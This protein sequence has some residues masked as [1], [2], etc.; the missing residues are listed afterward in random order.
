MPQ[1]STATVGNPHLA[2]L[3]GGGELGRLIAAFDWASTSIG[4]IGGW[5]QSLK[6]AISLIL[7]SRVPIVMLW[8]EDG[9][10]IYN[11]GYS[12]FAGGRHPQLLG[13]K[14]REG[15]PEVADFNDNIMKVCLGKGGTLAYREQVLT[16]NRTGKPEQVWLDLDYS[17]V[18]DES[19]EPAG[20]IAIVIETTAKVAAERWRAGERDRQRQMF[21]QAPG[22]M[23]M[24]SGPQHVVELTNAAYMQ[25]VGHR[26]IIGL[27]IRQALPEVEGQGF[28]ELLDQVFTSGEAFIGYALKAELQR[29]P[30]A[31]IEDRFIDLVYQ[32]V[33]NPAGEVFGIFVQGVDVTDRLIAEQALRQ[34]ET[35]FRTFAEAMPNHVWTATPEGLLDW[36]NPRVYDYSGARPGELD[37]HG[38]ADILHPDDIAAASDK[39]QQTVAA[40]TF[41]ETEF[42]LRRHD[43]IYR[44]FIA[45]A[46]PIRDTDGA[47]LRW[48][49]TNTDIDDQKQAA[50][51][52]LQSERR[53]QL[54]Q[55][56]AGIAA[57][58]LDIA[59]GTVV[60]SEGFWGL[61]GLSP[62]D[63]VH[64]SVLE[65]IVIPADK[66]VR[67]NPETREKG[68]AVP[69]VE[70]RIRRPD[71]GELRWLSRHIDFVHD[72]TGKPVKMFGVMQDVT[73]RREAQARQ[74]LLT[75]ELEHR[76]KN[77]LAMVAAIASQTLRNTDIAT[78]SA[79]FNE[80]LRALAN[81]HD[82]LN[83]TRW[84]SASIR[85][86]VDNTVA[87]FP[88]EQMSISG[89]ALPINPKMALTLALAVNELATNAL[90]YGALS[91]P[92][93]KVAIE[94]SLQP[95]QDKPSDIRLIWRWRESGGPPVTPPSRRGFGR[96]LIERV[97]GTD[98]GGTVRIDYHPDGVECVL[99]APAPQLPT[100][101][102]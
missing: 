59:S 3:S 58:E 23:A 49:G 11:D 52:L 89:P 60:G 44:W 33:R 8:G 96:F 57:L 28:F 20:V 75:H 102:Y 30:G 100:A 48:I 62:R 87:T 63:S 61:W 80:R 65:N 82:I 27:P 47:I 84:T 56:A 81:A 67:S 85:E 15:W 24:L 6:T 38:W 12:E 78:A 94:W 19:G 16:L 18:L 4:P 97:F 32:P 36:F 25:L 98:F 90:K 79:T 17:P 39:W 13:S 76:I 29:T 74:E 22:F 41:Y 71:T 46:V 53:L 7:R 42:R 10:M 1:T 68:T 9:V 99:N 73:D 101:P 55:N 69:A 2:F 26:D 86:V 88:L 72:E 66:D 45:R 35:Q 93:G 31:A 50:Q 70:Y 51:A 14:V 43:G 5:P 34:S 21:E 77:I 54:S 91:T 95:S 83:K 40:G 64:I 92:D 37:G